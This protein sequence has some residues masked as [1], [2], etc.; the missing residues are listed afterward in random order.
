M[1]ARIIIVMLS[2]AAMGCGDSDPEAPA[3][4]G[5]IDDQGALPA[6]TGGVDTAEPRGETSG[7]TGGQDS[8]VIDLSGPDDCWLPA[9]SAADPSFDCEALCVQFATCGP[10]PDD[11]QYRCELVRAYLRTEPS[12]VLRQCA[13]ALPCSEYGEDPLQTCVATE[14][15]AGTL[16]IP[17]SSQKVCD[18]LVALVVTCGEDAASFPCAGLAATYTEETMAGMGACAE[19]SDCE[20]VAHCL[21]G[22]FCFEEGDQDPGGEP[23][24]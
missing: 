1:R 23:P 2:L 22:A 13:M 7:E 15:A 16:T 18:D 20:E 12:L 17:P 24:P 21:H 11:C 6:D 4:A 5:T 10:T 14:L 3:D 9:T 19:L 8:K